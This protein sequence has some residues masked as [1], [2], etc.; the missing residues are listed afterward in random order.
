MRLNWSTICAL[1]ALAG[2]ASVAGPDEFPLTA[3]QLNAAWE[4]DESAWRRQETPD[5]RE[6][7]EQAIDPGG[8][9]SLRVFSAATCRWIERDRTAFCR[10]RTSRGVPPPGHQR[11]WTDESGELYLTKAGWSFSRP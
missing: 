5:E 11:S 7:R 9:L 8:F 6:Q 2:C 3:D 4:N 1:A 10:Y